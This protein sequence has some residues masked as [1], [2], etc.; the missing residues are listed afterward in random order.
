[1]TTGTR[2]LGGTK[3]GKDIVPFRPFGLVRLDYVNSSL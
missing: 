1:M 3:G 2:V